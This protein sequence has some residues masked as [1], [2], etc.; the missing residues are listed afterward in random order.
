MY[1]LS[2]IEIV[3]FSIE[4]NPTTKLKQIMCSKHVIYFRFLF[5][6]WDLIREFYIAKNHGQIEYYMTQMKINRILSGSF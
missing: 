2:C 3:C 1:T 4:L 6:V 5:D